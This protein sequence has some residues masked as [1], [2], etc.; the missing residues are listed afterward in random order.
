MTH[1]PAEQDFPPVQSPYKET[2]PDEAA[3][4]VAG[5]AVELETWV[6][7][8]VLLETTAEVAFALEVAATFEEEATAVEVAEVTTATF[9]EEAVVVIA[10][11]EDPPLAMRAETGV[12]PGK[13][14]VGMAGIGMLAV[15]PK[16]VAKS[17]AMVAAE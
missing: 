11:W 13:K 3:V 9:V 8:V 1:V 4:V 15:K 12:L 7:R 2:E 17:W 6:R 16:A 14:E 5:L 10:T